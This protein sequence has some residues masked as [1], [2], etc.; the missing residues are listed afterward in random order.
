M[1]LT[2]REREAIDLVRE[3]VNDFNA[4]EFQ[5]TTAYDDWC[6]YSLTHSNGFVR[7]ECSKLR[8]KYVKLGNDVA[9]N[10][11]YFGWTSRW[12]LPLLNYLT[13]KK[14]GKTS[15]SYQANLRSAINQIE[16]HNPDSI[17]PAE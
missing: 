6:S 9:I 3:L 16:N 10:M 17:D 1:R 4:W 8:V 11:P 2:I 13:Q 7:I 14:K 12:H 15:G 5:E